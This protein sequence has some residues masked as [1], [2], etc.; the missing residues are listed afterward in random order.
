MALLQENFGQQSQ[1]GTLLDPITD[2]F[3]VFVGLGTLLIEGKISLLL[4]V[5]LLSRDISLLFFSTYL[6][7]NGLFASYKIEA[8]RLGK[9]FTALQFLVFLLALYGTHFSD[10]VSVGFFLL[11][12]CCFFEL[13]TRCHSWQ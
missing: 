12:A 3:F 5:S 2:K 10:W 9:L 4:G 8:F 11:G 13:R 7:R 1:F 6:W